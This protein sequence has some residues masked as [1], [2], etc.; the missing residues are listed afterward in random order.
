MTTFFQ[1][2]RSMLYSHTQGRHRLPLEEHTLS[3]PFVET[4]THQ[5]FVT[6]NLSHELSL[7]EITFC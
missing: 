5:F 3:F 2:R 4:A 6:K 1:F 7:K